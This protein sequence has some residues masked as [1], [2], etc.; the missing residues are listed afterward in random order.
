M[1]RT[2]KLAILEGLVAGS[3]DLAIKGK[4][5][6][7][8]SMNGNMFAFLDPNDTLAFR[9]SNDDRSSFEDAF[10]PSEVRQYGSVMRGYVAIPDTMLHDMSLLSDWFGKCVD[11]AKTLKPK[12]TKK[13]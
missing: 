11:H 12:P 7:Y 10:G 4:K 3:D 6:P 9:L 5:M 1:D 2:A 13:P 8:L